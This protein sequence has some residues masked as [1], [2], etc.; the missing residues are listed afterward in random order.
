MGLADKIRKARESTVEVGGYTFTVRRPT[1]L[2]MFELQGSVSAGRLLPFVVGWSGVRNWTSFPVAIRTRC[3]SMQMPAPNGSRT[4]RTCS[5]PSSARCSIATPSTRALGSPQ[6][7]IAWRES[8]QLPSRQAP[9][10]YR[11]PR[12]ESLEPDGRP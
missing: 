8:T 10:R 5:G 1:D 9:R 6:K 11:E 2:E 12:G 3:P 4:G 7:L